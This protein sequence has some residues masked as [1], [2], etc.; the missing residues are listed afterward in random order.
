VVTSRA[1]PTSP[2]R[3]DR[4]RLLAAVKELIGRDP[5]LAEVHRR[6]GP[7]P[8]WARRPGFSALVKI[9]LEQQVSLASARAA[10]ERLRAAVDRLTPRAFLELDDATL[11]GAGFSRQKADYCRSLAEEIVAG[12]LRLA[13]V[14][15]MDDASAH[16]RLVRLRGV[17][18]WTADIYLLMALGR[19]DVWPS[20]D[21]ALAKAAQRVKGLAELPDDEELER[22]AAAW[23][24]WR[25]VA[26]RLLW[27]D[28][29]S[30]PVR[31]YGATARKRQ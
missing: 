16:R 24:P 13:D 21:L 17:G 15:R 12:R 20:G 29:L 22:I 31:P 1:E 11:R 3:L 14:A 2:G 8:L 19:P 4:D 30:R 28:Y 27:H 7:P 18:R 26:A 25:A 6:F 10:F 23:R 9:I 5:H